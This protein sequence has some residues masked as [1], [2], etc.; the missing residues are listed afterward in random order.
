M[1]APIADAPARAT[2]YWALAV[3]SILL[4]ASIVATVVQTLPLTT[5]IVLRSAEVQD[6]G[7]E[8]PGLSAL[9]QVR[10]RELVRVIGELAIVEPVA[11][12]F[13]TRYRDSQE[14]AEPLARHLD[15]PVQLVDSTANGELLERIANQYRGRLLVVITDVNALPDLITDLLGGGESTVQVAAD[16]DRLYIVSLPR[17]GTGRALPMRYG[18]PVTREVAGS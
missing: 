10:A 6:T 3:I 15:L 7:R 16:H 5:V 8:N 17:I 4:L 13:A 1:T 9:G 18:A 12:I 14:T 11:A 2:R